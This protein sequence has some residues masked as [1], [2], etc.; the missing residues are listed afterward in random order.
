[1]YTHGA[2]IRELHDDDFDGKVE[3]IEELS[4]ANLAIVE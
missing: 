3:K 1:V 2:L 4:V